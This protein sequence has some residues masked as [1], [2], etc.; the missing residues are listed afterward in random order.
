[1]QMKLHNELNNTSQAVVKRIKT[2]LIEK[3]I[4]LYRLE[5]NSG[6]LHGTMSSIMSG[7]TKKI[8]LSTIVLI[9]HGFNLSLLEFLNDP[10]F[11]YENLDV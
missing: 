9:A 8:S 6:I 10:L 5:R 2:L 1:M 3:N 11:E 4:T 7:K